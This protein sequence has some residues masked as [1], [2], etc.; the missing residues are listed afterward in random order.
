MTNMKCKY[1]GVNYKDCS[2]LSY[3]EVNGYYETHIC[4]LTRKTCSKYEKE[5]NK[6]KQN[7]F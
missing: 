2:N 3:K 7:N 6:K 1:K 4:L 5:I